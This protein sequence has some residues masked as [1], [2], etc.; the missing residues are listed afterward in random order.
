M[1]GGCTTLTE[2]LCP[3]FVSVYSPPRGPSKIGLRCPEFVSVYIPPI[4]AV[5]IRFPDVVRRPVF[6]APGAN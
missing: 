6:L 2:R 4:G 1:E 5:K 3:E